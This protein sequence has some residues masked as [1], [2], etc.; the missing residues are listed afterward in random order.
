MKRMLLL[1]VILSFVLL[2]S[3][4]TSTAGV[5]G[6]MTYQG[7][8]TDGGTPVT[9]TLPMTFTIYEDSSGLYA[10][11]TESQDEVVVSNGLFTVLLGSVYPLG[12]TVFDDTAR[13]LGVSI[14]GGRR[15]PH[16]H[17]W[18]ECPMPTG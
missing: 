10:I 2:G 7:R 9:D 8:L 5:P 1:T 6:V 16:G 4:I 14:D 17:G 12:D 15:L 11:W 3:A 13:W 18:A